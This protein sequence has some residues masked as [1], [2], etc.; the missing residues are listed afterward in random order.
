MSVL[1]YDLSLQVADL[2][3]ARKN[4]CWHNARTALLHL[5]GLFLFANYTEGWL[6]V[7]ETH[8]IQVI[9][10]GWLESV[11]GRI[12]DP[13]IVLL[14]PKE[15]PLE[16]FA[17]LRVSWFQMREIPA[18]WPLPLAHL[19]SQHDDGLD[20]PDYKA[21]YNT[22]LAYAEHLAQEAGKAVRTYPGG[23]TMV[24]LDEEGHV[25]AIL[26]R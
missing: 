14:A 25:L 2:I 10:H 20:H 17:S 16:Y 3:Q 15:Q 5:P 4:Q 6:V 8:E 22:A 26:H 24:V 9:E 19:A 11:G 1:D 21:A 12:V 13:S 23:Q 18:Q 7:P